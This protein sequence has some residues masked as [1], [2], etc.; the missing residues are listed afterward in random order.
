MAPVRCS[1]NVALS[2]VRHAKIGI[3]RRYQ[4]SQSIIASFHSS[5]SQNGAASPPL[6]PFKRNPLPVQSFT[7]NIDAVWNDGVC[8]ELA[9]D[10]D[11]QN[12]SSAEALYTWLGAFGSIFLLYNVI[13]SVTTGEKGNPALM[14]S[15][16]C[17][18]P[19]YSQQ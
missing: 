16:D 1:K 17:V 7:E 2:L 5:P 9:L 4:K 10:F 11:L 15:S 13:A 19:D 8:P 3:A 6:P 12:T 14:H 18:I